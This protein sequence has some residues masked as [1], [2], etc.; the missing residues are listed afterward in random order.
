M[1]QYR[2]TVET[3][4][5]K[6]PFNCRSVYSK[7]KH[8]SFAKILVYALFS[9]SFLH[10]SA[11]SSTCYCGGQYAV[12]SISKCLCVFAFYPAFTLNFRVELF[13]FFPSAIFVLRIFTFYPYP[14]V[15]VARR[16]RLIMNFAF[17]G[18]FY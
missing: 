9:L 5:V 1:H 14:L 6:C 4:T 15:M 3:V 2:P 8:V 11:V 18:A 12:Y 7:V 16:P 17:S 10:F 13:A